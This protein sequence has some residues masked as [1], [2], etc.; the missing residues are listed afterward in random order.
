MMNIFIL[1]VPCTILVTVRIC[2]SHKKNVE[3]ID[4]TRRC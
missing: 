1:L 2:L 4:E 3:E